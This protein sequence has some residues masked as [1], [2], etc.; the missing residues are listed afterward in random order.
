MFNRSRRRLL[1]ALF[2]FALAPTPPGA[3]AAE[4]AGPLTIVVPSGPG[5]APDIMARLIGDELRTRLGQAVVIENRPGAGGIVA[6]MA[7]RSAAQ[8]AN[9]LLFA[10]AAVVTVTPLTYRAAKYDME[11]DFE[12]V[13]VVAD[14]PMLFVANPAGGPR[15]LAEAIAEAKARPES[16]PLG[17]PSRGS[18]PHLSA[19]LLQLATGARF[20]VVPMSQSAQALQAV[21]SG[22]TLVSVDGIAPLLPLVKSGRLRAL[23]VTSSRTLPGLESLPLAKDIVPGLEVTGWFML[24]ANKGT[25]A[26]RLKALNEAVAA[27]LTSPQVVQKL[28]ATANYPVG[29]SLADAR[30]FLAREKK[31]WASAVQR[32][33]LLPE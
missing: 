3:L 16:I 13:A 2:A 15:S 1:A 14:T 28:Q 23:A 32:A 12:P 25:P 33:G 18:I 6:V 7:T 9:T 19:E 17:S 10:Q 4:A 30:A 29:G 20:N 8:P 24:F 27:A 21:A 5:S 26:A 31:M 22:D 11:R